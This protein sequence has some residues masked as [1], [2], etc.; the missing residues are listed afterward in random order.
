MYRLTLR[1]LIRNEQ[2]MSQNISRK[3]YLLQ[4]LTQTAKH[5][6]KNTKSIQNNHIMN[7][8]ITYFYF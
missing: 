8:C 3:Q 7:I 1:C 4:E 2:N 5:H 6:K